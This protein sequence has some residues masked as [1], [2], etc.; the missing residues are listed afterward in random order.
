MD[1]NNKLSVKL[2]LSTALA[3]VLCVGAAPARAQ[4]GM[5]DSDMKDMS[6]ADMMS[7]YYPA[8]LS[9]PFASPGSLNLFHWSDYTQ[10]D[11]EA[12]SMPDKMM[13][14]Q[15]AADRMHIYPGD[16]S[17]D[18]PM[19]GKTM[20]MS[21]EDMDHM[22]MWSGTSMDPMALSYPFAAPGSLDLFHWSD[23]S[24]RSLMTGSVE[25]TREH[26]QMMED[27]KRMDKMAM[28][29]MHHG[30]DMDAEDEMMD[31]A[32]LSYPFAAPGSLDL[33]HWRDYS[34]TELETGSTDDKRME[35]DQKKDPMKKMK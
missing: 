23:Y 5:H 12:G 17:Y 13:E 24:G 2:A 25:D 1:M 19:M 4:D 11:L 16:V 29:N 33:Y 14:M 34:K 31:P 27:Q 6:D 30:A 15:M 21:D 32:P 8:P 20:D 9:Y 18:K 22:G 7:M 10:T 35:N 26:N 3:L 28:S